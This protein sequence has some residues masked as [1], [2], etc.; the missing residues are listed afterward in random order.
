MSNAKAQC[1]CCQQDGAEPFGEL[2][3]AIDLYRDKEGNLIQI[4][5]IAQELY[6]HLSLEL[7]QYIADKLN[8]P[9]SEVS[10]LSRGCTRVRLLP[11]LRGRGGRRQ[12]ACSF[13]H[14]QGIRGHEDPHQLGAGTP[15]EEGAV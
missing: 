10:V 7:Q 12:D 6:G 5:H 2:D 9:L 11:H 3:A 13:V 4:L 15:R 8:K 1:S 14:D